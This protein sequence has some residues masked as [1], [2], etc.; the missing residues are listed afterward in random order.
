M[1][2]LTR[3]QYEVFNWIKGKQN[4]SLKEIG[5]HFK[6]KESTVFFLLKKLQDKNYIERSRHARSIKILKENLEEISDKPLYHWVYDGTNCFLYRKQNLLDE[7]VCIVPK[8][9]VKTLS[10]DFNLFID[11]KIKTWI[12]TI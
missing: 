11:E 8:D 10:E 5:D 3:R 7:P 12:E 1:E 2:K 4:V 6:I 9:F